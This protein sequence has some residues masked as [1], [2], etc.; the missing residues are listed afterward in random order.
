MMSVWIFLP[1]WS[2]VAGQC[3]SPPD[4]TFPQ[5]E[6]T[7]DYVNSDAVSAWSGDSQ[8]SWC[9]PDSRGPPTTIRLPDGRRFWPSDSRSVVDPRLYG[10]HKVDLRHGYRMKA[11]DCHYD[12]LQRTDLSIAEKAERFHKEV[13][14][15]YKAERLNR[16]GE[17]I[18][19]KPGDEEK[20]VNLMVKALKINRKWYGWQYTNRPWIPRAFT[21]MNWDINDIYSRY[22]ATLTYTTKSDKEWDEIVEAFGRTQTEF[23]TLL[24]LDVE[25]WQRALE[26][27]SKHP[28]L[29]NEPCRDYLEEAYEAWSRF[30]HPT[31]EHVSHRTINLTVFFNRHYTKND[32]FDYFSLDQFKPKGWTDPV[33]ITTPINRYELK[34]VCNI[35]L[36]Q[37]FSKTDPPLQTHNR[38]PQENRII[39]EL[40]AN[41]SYGHLDNLDF[42]HF[43]G[44]SSEWGQSIIEPPK[45]Y[46]PHVPTCV[47][48]FPVDPTY[49]DSEDVSD[50]GF[51]H[52]ENITTR[53]PTTSPITR[54]FNFPNHMVFLGP[55]ITVDMDVLLGRNTRPTRTTP[56]RRTR[57]RRPRTTSN[58]T[59][60][61]TP[62]PPSPI[63]SKPSHWTIM[64]METCKHGLEIKNNRRD[65]L[66][67]R[68]VFKLLKSNRT[69]VTRRTYAKITTT[70]PAGRARR[71]RKTRRPTMAE[72]R[73]D[74]HVV[75]KRHVNGN[76]HA[77]NRILGKLKR[78]MDSNVLRKKRSVAN[79]HR[80]Q[81]DTGMNNPIVNIIRE[82]RL[83]RKR[84]HF[85]ESECEFLSKGTRD[86][87]RDKAYRSYEDYLKKTKKECDEDRVCR[88]F[89]EELRREDSFDG[90]GGHWN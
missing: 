82:P 83:K 13:G 30:T 65:M 29:T 69:R 36:V 42:G 23:T 11:M 62:T 75:R 80:E 90:I 85:D 54:N 45:T 46:A 78:V 12:L 74:T 71:T 8:D 44:E 55:T 50:Y 24:P 16:S 37:L 68:S 21:T 19:D 3:T 51:V 15:L 57:R 25:W 38:S 52:H 66:K 77:N 7:S 70:C 20:L 2:A 35:S 26:Y 41:N 32:T 64:E 9:W 27:S 88:L 40:D 63:T 43:Q 53:R 81:F 22:Y 28:N 17:N 1:L 18:L 48:G 60:T 14:D 59:R 73:H 49:D 89:K 47:H 79:Q 72:P 5:S 87:A 86:K 31:T 6:E 84:R 61:P 33:V 10:H 58:S 67:L 76:Q 39:M 4:Q 34:D 56:T